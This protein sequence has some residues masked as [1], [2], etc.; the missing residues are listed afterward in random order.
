MEVRRFK[1]DQ[2]KH[3]RFSVKEHAQAAAMVHMP[4]N[5]LVAVLLF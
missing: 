4:K 2:K 3:R 1:D 5:S